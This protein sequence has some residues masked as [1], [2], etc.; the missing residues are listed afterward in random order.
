MKR[1]LFVLINLIITSISLAQQDTLFFDTDWKVCSKAYASYYRISEKQESG[2]FMIKDAYIKTN[3][4]QMVGYSLTIEPT[5]LYGKCTYYYPSGKKESEG[6]YYNDVK[7][8]MWINWSKSGKDS[9]F[10]NYGV[11]NKKIIFEPQ[12][13][14]KNQKIQD[15]IFR[16]NATATSAWD[17][18][19][20]DLL[21]EREGFSFAARGKVA[22]FFIIE[23]VFFL[24]YSLGTEFSYNKHSLGLDYTWFR[25]RYEEDNSDDVGMYSQYE[26]RTYLHADYKY[27]YWEYP[28]LEF[29]LYL[30]VYDKI[31]EYKMWYDKYSE[32]DFGSRDM[33]FLES[34]AKGT[35]NEPGLGIGIRKYAEQTGFGFDCSMNVGY[36]M[37]N[38]DEQT[39]INAFETDFRDNVKTEKFLF[40]MRMNCFYIFGR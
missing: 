35:F 21:A 38:N 14:S 6:Y 23:D 29:D 25:W 40:Y 1:F 16:R 26:L 5:N 32:Y 2:G 15:S 37:M 27:T 9:T 28:R 30:N 11:V 3:I 24:T 8:G 20:V 31:G 10:K 12:E 33:T 13:L 4:P 17:S 7:T 36:R 22:T 34:K 19:I 18:S 39:Y